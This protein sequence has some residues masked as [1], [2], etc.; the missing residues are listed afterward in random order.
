MHILA[1]TSG[2]ALYTE[3]IGFEPFSFD[4]MG[5][6][7]SAHGAEVGASLAE[8]AVGAIAADG[9]EGE[10]FFAERLEESPNLSCRWV[11]I[12]GRRIFRSSL[13]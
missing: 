11:F 7:L 12:I 6:D 2:T 9:I 13:W 5:A 8:S 3:G 1:E 10:I 4:L